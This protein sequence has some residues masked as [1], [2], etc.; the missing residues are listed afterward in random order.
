MQLFNSF[1]KLYKFQ[2]LLVS[3]YLSCGLEISA[4]VNDG[5]FRKLVQM[6][7]CLGLDN[8]IL[9][10]IQTLNGMNGIINHIVRQIKAAGN[11]SPSKLFDDVYKDAEKLT[12]N[13]DYESRQMERLI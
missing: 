7:A 8:H 5:L 11:L 6:A 9:V 2:R 3:R 1:E 10:L 4:F 13:Y 12:G